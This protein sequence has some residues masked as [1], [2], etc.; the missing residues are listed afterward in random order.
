MTE[1][2]TVEQINSV[3]TELKMVELSDESKIPLPR[4]TNKKVLALVKYI[5]GDGLIIYN[6]YLK[7]REE[8]TEKSPALDENGQQ[9]KDDDGELLWNFKY[10]TVEQMVEFALEVL[11]DEKIAKLLAIILDKSVDEAE[12]MDF[13]DTSMIVGAF[14]DNT[15]IDKLTILVKKIQKKFRPM[16]QENLEK[17]TQKQ[18]PVVPLNP[19]Q[20]A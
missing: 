3:V 17:A 7:W 10:P 9:K 12:E 16:S 20:Q 5:A 19:S 14:L 6:E 15:P 4:L 1:N 11:P 13:F 2:T 8:N 18:A